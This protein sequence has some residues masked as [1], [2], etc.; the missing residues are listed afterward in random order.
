MR[1]RRR[2]FLAILL[3]TILMVSAVSII[4]PS[5]DDSQADDALGIA[6]GD[7][8][9]LFSGRGSTTHLSGQD[10]SVYAEN[11]KVT[12]TFTVDS[13]P[14]GY[15]DWNDYGTLRMTGIE[16]S[17]ASD[18]LYVFSFAVQKTKVDGKDAFAYYKVT[19]I[20]DT[21]KTQIDS[22]TI[23]VVLP[24]Q[25]RNMSFG[26]SVTKVTE[27]SYTDTKG[28]VVHYSIDETAAVYTNGYG[29]YSLYAYNK[30]N[31]DIRYCEQGTVTKV[32]YASGQTTY[33]TKMSQWAANDLTCSD[34]WVCGSYPDM[35]GA[36]MTYDLKFGSENV[37][38][39]MKEVRC[40]S[41]AVITVSDNVLKVNAYEITASYDDGKYTF[42]G[43][44][45]ED[46]SKVTSD[47]NIS[48]DV[49]ANG[50]PGSDNV[51]VIIVV[52][53]IAVIAI[54]VLVLSRRH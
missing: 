4:L 21:V 2:S 42:K 38:Y 19:A 10:K 53:V 39:S 13:L 23:D 37:D 30:V 9:T 34:S 27:G 26:S 12:M 43:W 32:D 14:K 36:A 54:A 51:P 50:S 48:A 25:L 1:D 44:S 22:R 8:M 47:M 11:A 35:I 52:V 3:I 17:D 41:N 28:N 20:D 31:P 15:D 6:V 33:D 49:E 5:S 18:I 16:F 45:V 40:G 7:T 46:G 24:Q 29:A